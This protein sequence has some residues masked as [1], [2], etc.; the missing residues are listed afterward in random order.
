[1]I[2]AGAQ[3]NMGPAGVTVVIVRKDILGKVSRAIP[4]MMNYQIHIDKETMFNTPPVFPIFAMLQN[5]KWVKKCGGVDEMQKRAA[6]RADMLYAE[7]DSNPLFKGNVEVED[8]SQ[9]NVCFVLT[10]ESLEEKFNAAWKAAGISGIKGHRSAGGYRASMYNA[11]PL[12]SVEA[13]V[14]VMRTF[15]N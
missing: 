7:I 6:A 13:L 5:L 9:M 12:E 2:Y 15:N 8:R 10:D 14:N 1:L 11:L 3:K 4:S